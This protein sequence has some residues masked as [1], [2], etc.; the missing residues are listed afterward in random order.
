MFNS[1]EGSMRFYPDCNA[2]DIGQNFDPMEG[3]N[4]I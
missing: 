3:S 1:G 4:F 2:S